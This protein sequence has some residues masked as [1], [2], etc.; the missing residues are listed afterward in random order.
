MQTLVFLDRHYLHAQ[1]VRLSNNVPLKL[2]KVRKFVLG[3][4]VDMLASHSDLLF[5]SR[6]AEVPWSHPLVN[7]S[8]NL[9]GDFPGPDTVNLRM[10]LTGFDYARYSLLSFIQHLESVFT[11]SHS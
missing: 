6:V 10:V 4:I 3:A 1:E 9:E 2:H 5:G 11:C 8:S 7:I